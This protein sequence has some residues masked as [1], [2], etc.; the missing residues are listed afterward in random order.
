MAGPTI[1]SVAATGAQMRDEL[2][3]P[4]LPCP[5]RDLRTA[6]KV[7]TAVGKDVFDRQ[8]AIE[9]ANRRTP[10]RIKLVVIPPLCADLI[11]A[12]DIYVE[13][14]LFNWRGS[15]SAVMTVVA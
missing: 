10:D 4:G 8:Q 14:G 3:W 11:P 6:T 9:S 2:P 5:D 12:S 15:Y 7:A 13:T 1:G